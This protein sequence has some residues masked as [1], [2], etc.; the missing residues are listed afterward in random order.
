MSYELSEPLQFILIFVCGIASGFMG[1]TVGSGGALGL[2]LLLLCGLPPQT[3]V[4]TQNAGD[5]FAVGAAFR[6]YYASQKIQW[7]LALGLIPL[8][9]IGAYIGSQIGL[10]LSS[11]DLQS[12]IGVVLLVLGVILLWH[13]TLGLKAREVSVGFQIAGFFAVFLIAI[14]SGAVPAG[15]ATLLLIV[16]TTLL[17]KEIVAGYAT[18]S[19]PYQDKGGFETYLPFHLSLRSS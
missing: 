4:G 17:G 1:G 14:N 13:R 2:P 5:L 18:L 11:Q 3:A 12:Y 19:V 9:A 7:K 16:M 10:L 6:R 8:T 15:G